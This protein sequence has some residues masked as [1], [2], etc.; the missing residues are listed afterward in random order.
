LAVNVAEFNSPQAAFWKGPLHYFS[1]VAGHEAL[2]GLGVKNEALTYTIAQILPAIVGFSLGWSLGGPLIALA[3]MGAAL[4]VASDILVKLNARFIQ[5]SLRMIRAIS[6]MPFRNLF[7]G[8][9]RQ[10]PT[11]EEVQNTLRRHVSEEAWE[12]IRQR[13]PP[14]KLNHLIK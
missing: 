3:G 11:P 13:T 2:H 6:T 5:D 8:F 7:L 12:L 14:E 4:Y 10:R 9:K 1:G